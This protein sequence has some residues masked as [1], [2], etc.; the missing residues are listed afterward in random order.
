MNSTN[1]FTH[2]AQYKG[3][4]QSYEMRKMPRK[5]K[6][7]K[8]KLLIRVFVYLWQIETRLT[9]ASLG[10]EARRI[11]KELQKKKMRK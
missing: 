9:Y 6:S 2:L 11:S 4:K 5:H 3:W 10:I 7:S 1:N 8:F